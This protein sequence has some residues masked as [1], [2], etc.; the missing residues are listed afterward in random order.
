MSSS[1]LEVVRITTGM[2]LKSESSL[3]CLRTSLP[4]MIGKLRSRRI[5]SGRGESEYLPCLRRQL[6]ASCPFVAIIRLL[7]TLL[8]FNTSWV[9]RTSPALS[10][11]SKMSTGIGNGCKFILFSPMRLSFRGRHRETKRDS[12]FRRRLDPNTASVALDDLLANSEADARPGILGVRVK[13]LKDD[14]DS[15]GVL[16]RDADAVVLNRE[17]PF[18]SIPLA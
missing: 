17:F 16:R 18:L 9:S 14:E 4:S 8:P 2:R 10:S 15:V 7:R 5:K 6:S 1:A 13:P 11:T 3:I 12:A